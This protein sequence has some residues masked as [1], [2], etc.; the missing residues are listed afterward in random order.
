MSA[1]DPFWTLF[2]YEKVAELAFDCY[3]GFPVRIQVNE[4]V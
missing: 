3:F 2:V 1:F 4:S